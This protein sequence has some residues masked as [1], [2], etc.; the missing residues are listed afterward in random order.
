[1]ICKNPLNKF[2][3]C[4]SI[5][6]NYLSS[7]AGLEYLNLSHNEVQGTFPASFGNQ[8][9]SLQDIDLSFNN[10]SGLLLTSLAKL[11]RLQHLNVSYNHFS[12]PV[13]CSRAY[14][15]QNMKSFLGT[16]KK[17]KNGTLL[18]SRETQITQIFR[19]RRGENCYRLQCWW[20][21]ITQIFRRWRG[22]NCY[23]LAAPEALPMLFPVSCC[24]GCG[25]AVT[26]SGGEKQQ[27]RW[28]IAEKRAKND[29]Q[30]RFVTS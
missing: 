9:K 19:R 18:W 24:P 16:L 21:Q 22:G 17:M 6:I 23:R 5:Q 20:L 7:Y 1:M 3:P 4:K 30:L 11:E 29:E 13:P 8:L 15:K 28:K 14:K 10:L 27:K 26:N 25:G 2:Y 12:G